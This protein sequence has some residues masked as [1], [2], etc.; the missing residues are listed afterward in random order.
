MLQNMQLAM[1]FIASSIY[2]GI[3]DYIIMSLNTAQFAGFI[4]RLV[5]SFKPKG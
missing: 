2:N 4:F 3:V 1:S 5:K